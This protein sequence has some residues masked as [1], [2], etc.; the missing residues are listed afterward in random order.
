MKSYEFNITD[1]VKDNYVDFQR[2]RNG[3]FYYTVY[4]PVSQQTFE[5]PVP[6]NDIGDASLR[7]SVKAIYFMRYMYRA[8][9]DGTFVPYSPG[10]NRD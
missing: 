6:L 7:E 2:F 4:V 9:N 8:M 3:T 10:E 5:F 1:I